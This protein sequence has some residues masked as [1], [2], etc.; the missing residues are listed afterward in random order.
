MK[1]RRLKRGV[2]TP[3]AQGANMLSKKFLGR[4][5]D[6]YVSLLQKPRQLMYTNLLSGM[7][8]GFGIAFGFTIF[9]TVAVWV[10]NW[11]GALDLPLIGDFIADLVK[12]VQRQLEG[13]RF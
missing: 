7:V 12:E 6:D 8:R 10:L 9:T 2:S 1:V 4:E 3:N 5:I 11:L 13:R